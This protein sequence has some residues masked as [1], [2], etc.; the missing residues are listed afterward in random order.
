MQE[1]GKSFLQIF[2]EGDLLEAVD[3]V[4][5]QSFYSR[6]FEFLLHEIKVELK[7]SFEDEASHELKQDFSAFSVEILCFQEEKLDWGLDFLQELFSLFFSQD[8][9]LV[10]NLAAERSKKERLGSR[11][12]KSEEKG[13]D[14]LDHNFLMSSLYIFFSFTQENLHQILGC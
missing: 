6:I 10:Q 3:Q 5:G 2:Y 13:E 14:S 4:Q 12:R 1:L 7:L 9:E 11:D 8:R